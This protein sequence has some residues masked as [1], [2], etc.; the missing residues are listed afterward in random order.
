MEERRKV[1]EKG[2]G[3]MEERGEKREKGEKGEKR[4]E[5]EGGSFLSTEEDFVSWNRASR[6]IEKEGRKE[7]GGW[8]ED[9][10]KEK[11]EEGGRR[12]RGRVVGKVVYNRIL[13]ATDFLE[14]LALNRFLTEEHVDVIFGA[15]VGY[16]RE[17]SKKLDAELYD[18]FD[19]CSAEMLKYFLAKFRSLDVTS[20]DEVVMTIFGDILDCMTR[21][22]AFLFQ[23]FPEKCSMK[24]K[25]Q[26]FANF[27]NFLRAL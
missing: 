10:R 5:E 22:S 4:E 13:V 15:I 7:R 17:E 26:L 19:G 12:R 6:G 21:V 25:F 1:G 14:F 18:F 24:K 11:R 3:R 2:G 16:P 23:I 8:R 20:L 27:C 9:G